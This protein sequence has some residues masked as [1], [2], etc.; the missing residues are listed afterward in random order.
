MIEAA[1]IALG[2]LLGAF[3]YKGDKPL[4]PEQSESVELMRQ[5]GISCGQERMDSYSIEY[6]KCECKGEKN[7]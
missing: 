2:L 1:I 4:V 6:G 7:D 5:C 3:V